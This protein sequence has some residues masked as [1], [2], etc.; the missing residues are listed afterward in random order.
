MALMAQGPDSSLTLDREEVARFARL[1]GEWWDPR[2]PFGQLHRINPVRLT[3]IRDQICSRFGRDPKQA[4]SL[5]GLSILDIGCGG[6]LVCEPLARLGCRMTGIDPGQEAIEAAKAH[7]SAAGLHIDYPAATA[8]ELVGRG[9]VFDAVLLLEV[10]EHVPDVPK[11]LKT[12]APLVKPE[13]LMILSTLNRTLKAYALAIVGAELILRWLPVG[14]HQWQR[15]V[16]PDE[17]RSALQGA[18]LTLTDTRGLI[19]DP[20]ADEWRLGRDTDV[21]YFATASRG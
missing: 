2:G 4:S 9:E 18:D 3:Y 20:L 8:E 6:G 5:A 16:R 15:F 10:V 14:T 21:N 17:L 13:G 19:Y 7:A 12:V 1:G 11:F